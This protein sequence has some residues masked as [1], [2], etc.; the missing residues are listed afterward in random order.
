MNFDLDEF[1]DGLKGLTRQEA[2]SLVS[3]T[4]DRLHTYNT[5]PKKNKGHVAL[6]GHMTYKSEEAFL[7]KL[8]FEL[9][10]GGAAYYEGKDRERNEKVFANLKR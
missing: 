7:G 4:R 2:I 1:V 8:L 5:R 10:T 6:Y 9:Q 3:S